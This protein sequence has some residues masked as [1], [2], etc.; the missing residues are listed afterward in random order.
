MDGAIEN[1]TRLISELSIESRVTNTAT[2]TQATLTNTHLQNLNLLAHQTAANIAQTNIAINN[3]L[4][5]IKSLVQQLLQVEEQRA[6]E[7]RRHRR[8][9]ERGVRGE[10]RL[11]MNPLVT[12][13]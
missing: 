5:E 12:Q 7:E 13:V 8:R 1:V 9:Q 11:P 4:E 2:L 3:T 6:N 10:Q